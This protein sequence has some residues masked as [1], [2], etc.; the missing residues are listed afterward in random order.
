[1]AVRG[2]KQGNIFDDPRYQDFVDRYHADPLKFAIECTGFIPSGDQID[3]FQA[4]RC[5]NAR[6]SVVSGTGTGKT[7]AFARVALWHLLC[8]PV[9]IYEGK[10]EIGSN[11][12]IG[13]PVVQQVANGVWKEMQDT[14]LQIANGPH[15]WINDY[16]E[17]TKTMVYVKGYESQWFINQ[18]AL[19]PGQATSIAGKHRYMQLIIVDEASGVSD[20]HFDVINGTQTQGANRTLLASQ[21]TRCAGFFYDTHHTLAKKNGGIWEALRFSSER[22]PFV[23][24]DWL[25]ARELEAGGR[26]SVEYQ[27]RVLGLFAQSTSNV[28]MTRVD[29]ERVFEDRQ[30]IGDDEPYGYV[31]LCDVALGEYRDESVIWIAKVIGSE[32]QG[33]YARRV[34]FIALPLNSNDKEAIDLAG[35][36]KEQTGRYSNSSLYVDNGGIGA[37]VNQMIERDGGQV[38]KINWG[39]PCFKNEYRGRF[40]NLRACAMVRFRDAVR[41]GRVV[42]RMKLDKRTKEKIIDQATRLPYHFSDTG[43]LRYVI[44]TKE[45]MRKEGIKSPDMIDCMSFAFLENCSYMASDTAAKTGDTQASKLMHVADSLFS[46]IEG[47]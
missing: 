17:I 20:K 4:M 36:L 3:L 31:V 37:M 42:I 18:L 30:I 43:A 28:L 12:Y 45:N 29:I 14:R 44:E 33:P 19:Q 26:N 16:Y 1:M 39:Q 24:A 8:H 7:A 41:Q 46:D 22:S 9:A 32:D 35:E 27:I 34:E 23:T 10:I 15:A 11:T 25:H 21:G 6:V 47:L 38:N 13:A 5:E 2:K 40:Y